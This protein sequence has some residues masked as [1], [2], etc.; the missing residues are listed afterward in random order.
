MVEDA[1]GPN[2]TPAFR[3][4][5]RQQVRDLLEVAKWKAVDLPADHREAWS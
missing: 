5:A 1:L 3:V 2:S 4:L